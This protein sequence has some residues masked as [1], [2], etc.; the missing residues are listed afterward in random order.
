MSKKGDECEEQQSLEKGTES[1]NECKWIF[2]S[3]ILCM[4][5][6]KLYPI[7]DWVT[8]PI[9]WKTVVDDGQM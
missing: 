3:S 7:F 9:L 8:S 5:D 2:A 1:I 4:V 6:Q